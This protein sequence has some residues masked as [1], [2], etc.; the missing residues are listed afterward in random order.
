[1]ERP[2][3]PGPTSS[4]TPSTDEAGDAVEPFD[5]GEEDLATRITHARQR[6]GIAGAALAAGMLGLDQALYGRKPKEEIP[7]VVD[8]SGEPTDVDRD[9]ISLTV[10]EVG[11]HVE[12]PPL[13]R[14]APIVSP[15]RRGRRR[16][17]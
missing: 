5:L 7:I 10:D 1:M 4:D 8:A 15:S 9:G 16:S 13:P 11:L 2:L 14:R 3:V 12:A 6:H 17:H